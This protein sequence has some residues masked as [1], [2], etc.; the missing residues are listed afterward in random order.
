MDVLAA[1]HHAAVQMIDTSVVRVH[2]HG[3]WSRSPNPWS[4]SCATAGPPVSRQNSS[5]TWF[6]TGQCMET[7]PLSTERAPY[8]AALVASS[9]T[10]TVIDNAS[11]AGR[12]TA[13]PTINTREAS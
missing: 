7:T 12:K 6:D 8:F 11:F 13:G 4:V 9:R 3:A 5:I 10:I 1:G 2:Q